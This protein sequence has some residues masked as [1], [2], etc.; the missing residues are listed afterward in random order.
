MRLTYAAASK[1]R[2][3]ISQGAKATASK[4]V[5]VCSAATSS[6]YCPVVDS[7][8]G[9]GKGCTKGNEADVSFHGY[10]FDD[11]NFYWD[12]LKNQ[13][14]VS[15]TASPL[16]SIYN[17]LLL[18][19]YTPFS[20]WAL[21]TLIACWLQSINP[22]HTISIPYSKNISSSSRRANWGD[23]FHYNANKGLVTTQ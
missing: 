8:R 21:I 20:A 18:G 13:C 4:T 9:D 22:P 15:E 12:E 14:S 3:S 16:I 6:E 11:F 2:P 23:S 17:F 7:W 1:T 19:P 10:G 5:Y